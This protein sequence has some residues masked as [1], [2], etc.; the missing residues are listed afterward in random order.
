MLR[1]AVFTILALC[2]ACTEADRERM[3]STKRAPLMRPC[4]VQPGYP[5]PDQRPGCE[6]VGINTGGK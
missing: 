5:P 1:V 4:D 3:F 2:A 6:Y